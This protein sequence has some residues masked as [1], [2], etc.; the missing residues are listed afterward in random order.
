MRATELDAGGWTDPV[1]F[2][3]ALRAAIGEP[4]V[5]GWSPDA[6]VDSMIWGGMNSVE[7]P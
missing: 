5:H 2:L 1:D 6:F 7:S 4:E 3:R